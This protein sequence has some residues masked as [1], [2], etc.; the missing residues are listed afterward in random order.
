[1][2]FFGPLLVLLFGFALLLCKSNN[3]ASAAQ[4]IHYPAYLRISGP[5]DATTGKVL[6]LVTKPIDAVNTMQLKIAGS[7]GSV[8]IRVSPWPQAITLPECSAG[9]VAD[10]HHNL[11]PDGPEWRLE[12]KRG[13]KTSL[14][15]VSHS[16][17]QR[18][19][20]PEALSLEPGAPT[21][22]EFAGRKVVALKANGKAIVNGT[23]AEIGA[24]SLFVAQ[25][26]IAK[27][28]RKGIAEE[29]AGFTSDWLLSCK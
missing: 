23:S 4:A 24:C 16:R 14:L 26:S 18:L 2:R 6:E 25:A 3:A 15:V 19:A 10:Y 8:Q 29:A 13:A 11:L 27:A 1:M 17:L 5:P 12:I 7:E 22:A 21:G 9:C 20:L 28:A